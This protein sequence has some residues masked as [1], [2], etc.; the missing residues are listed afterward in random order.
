MW[1]LILLALLRWFWIYKEEHFILHYPLPS[2]PVN[3]YLVL[4]DRGPNLHLLPN[5]SAISWPIHKRPNFTRTNVRAGF[6]LRL[7]KGQ[8]NTLQY[9]LKEFERVMI[10]LKLHDRWFLAAGTLIGSMRHHDI[11]PWDDDLDVYAD[12]RHRATIQSALR[13]L[14]PRFGTHA[15][16][17]YDKIFFKPVGDN[18]TV[19]SSTI[20]SFKIPNWPWAWPFVDI[21]YFKHSHSNKVADVT[22]HGF[23][24]KPHNVFPLTYRPFGQHWYP[25]PRNPISL[26]SA[27]YHSN[28]KLCISSYYSHA[29]ERG[30]PSTSLKCSNLTHKYAFVRRCPVAEAKRRS[31]GLQFCDEYLVGGDGQS[32]HKI[33]TLLDPAE[34]VSP[35]YTLQQD[36]FSCP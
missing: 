2:D 10:S 36:L 7:S 18:E 33:R 1:L 3:P 26:L 22:W 21:F 8:Y 23:S 17:R 34:I 30:I 4:P 6:D 13:S 28:G 35:L 11:I 29:I 31:D 32:M 27:T 20:G 15:M 12:L 19:N 14:S 16:P 9:L 5:L 24:V 25:A